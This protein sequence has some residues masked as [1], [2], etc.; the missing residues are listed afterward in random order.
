LKVDPLRELLALQQ[1]IA[2]RMEE[3]LG[4]G[5]PSAVAEADRGSWS[6]P[7]DLYETEEAFVF[8]ADLPGFAAREVTFT[9][10][11]RLL[12]V[13]GLRKGGKR[14]GRKTGPAPG[15]EKERP[16]SGQEFHRMERESG[17]FQRS[18]ELSEGVN[19]A[20]IVNRWSDGVLEVRLPKAT[21]KATDKKGKRGS[22]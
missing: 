15:V 11:G 19:H 10:E 17:T 8:K 2:R 7:I 9:L 4:H 14:S 18:F 5:R 12:T 13:R 6:P 21:T 3:R 16:A 20:R 22:R 1:Q